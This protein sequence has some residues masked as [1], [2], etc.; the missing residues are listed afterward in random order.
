[1]KLPESGKGYNY[2][3]WHIYNEVLKTR[4]INSFILDDDIENLYITYISVGQEF[5][6]YFID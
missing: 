6:N 4:R 2:S 1:M 3:L 5:I